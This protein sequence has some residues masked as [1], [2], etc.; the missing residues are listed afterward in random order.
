[1]YIICPNCN[2]H[3]RLDEVYCNQCGNKIAGLPGTDNNDRAIVTEDAETNTSGIVIVCDACGSENALDSGYCRN[4]GQFFPKQSKALDASSMSSAVEPV[5]LPT[6]QVNQLAKD[7]QNPA[8]DSVP[9]LAQQ[10]PSSQTFSRQLVIKKTGACLAIPASNS[11]IIIGRSDPVS[12]LF[13]EIDLEPYDPLGEGVSRLHA[14]LT[15]ENG[16]VFIEDLKSVNYTHV[17]GQRL[18]PGHKLILRPGDEIILGRMRLVYDVQ[19]T[20]PMNSEPT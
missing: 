19:P 15:I 4:C 8:L 17:N 16:Q 20:F 10:P 11:E 2:K 1:M 6:P 12:D 14:R 5:S 3:N 13:P 7:V 18:E 9:T